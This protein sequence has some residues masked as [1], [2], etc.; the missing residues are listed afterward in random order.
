MHDPL[1]AVNIIAKGYPR[2]S[3]ELVGP[4][5]KLFGPQETHKWFQEKLLKRNARLK[6]ESDG[7][8]FPSTDN[9][10]T[11][12]DLL[13]DQ[14]KRAGVEI[15]SRTRATNITRMPN[16]QFC[17]EF[18]RNEEKGSI[19]CDRVI[20]ATGSAKIGYT[21]MKQLGHTFAE[22][23]PSLF[24]FR[25]I[26]PALTE[27]SGVS[28]QFA[29]VRLILPAEFTQNPRCKQLL[30]EVGATVAKPKSKAV[31]VV[32]GGLTQVGP[33]LITMQ[34]LSGP[35][36]LKLSA[37]AA[38]ILHE[39]N[40]KFEIAVN[41][42]GEMTA[43][44]VFE[45]LETEKKTH[46]NRSVGKRFPSYLDGDGDEVSP[47]K[48]SVAVEEASV[49]ITRR[50]WLY[51]LKKAG[52]VSGES[53]WSSVDR[54]ALLAVANLVVADTFQVSGRGM[55]KDEFVTCGGVLLKEVSMDS[56]ESKI[57]PG[58]FLAGELLDIDGIT[59]GYNLQSA[60]TTGYIAGD[61]CGRSLI[62]E[63]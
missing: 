56:L 48:E 49:L 3:K 20:M 58:L 34:G 59:G 53:K 25:I 45:L 30:R 12:V 52:L 8:V 44:E 39:L 18:V 51:L 17:L 60:W 15:W 5:T 27:L 19:V 42:A 47:Q 1:K 62:E 6:T 54:S 7:R 24:S 26:D 50:L 35:A 2:G 55:Y 22:P 33:L 40:Y 36:V 43:E 61:S 16:N 23:L 63:P 10:T 9:S 31:S 57:V 29:K 4:F 21:M 14:A 28:V 13:H 37:F 41:W 38:R 32:T 46:P 11:I